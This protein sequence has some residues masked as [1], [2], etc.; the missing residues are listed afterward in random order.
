MKICFF[1]Y[2]SPAIKG[3]TMGGGELQVFLLAKALALDGHEVV[4]IDPYGDGNFT[5]ADGI[6]VI[7][8]PEWKKGFKGW[9]LFTHRIPALFRAFKEQNA[10]YYYVRM[11]SYIHLIPYIVARRN[12]RKFIQAVASDI[13]VLNEW[14][15]YKYEYRANFKL[16]KFLSQFLPS[17]L[18]FNYLLNNADYVT[19]QHS[20]Q[21]FQNTSKTKQVIFSNIID[22]SNLPVTSVGLKEY[23]IY[24]GSLTMLKGADNLLKL[25]NSIDPSICFVIVGLPKGE[26]AKSIYNALGKKPNVLLKGQKDHKE[27][28]ELISNAK[29]LINTSYYEGFPN[30]YL[31]AWATGVPVV[32]LTVNPGNIFNNYRLGICCNSSLEKM[33]SCIETNATDKF[34]PEKLKE[35]VSEYH[36]FGS[37]A[38][39]FLNAVSPDVCS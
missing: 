22:T 37:A 10:D 28:I 16:S 39:R 29:A 7:T 4:I 23:Y 12:G 36:D 19:L 32:S 2:I 11:R 3:K 33:K 18:A 9:R 17:D 20:G 15:K 1:G 26:D 13:D 25:I 38:R 30:I 27:T 34:Q 14:K 35:Y 21:R 24:V 8:I 31:E 5:T 6:K